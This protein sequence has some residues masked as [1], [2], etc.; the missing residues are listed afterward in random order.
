MTPLFVSY[1]CDWCDG[2]KRPTVVARGFVVWPEEVV[3]DAME[4]YV[5][6]TRE[7][8]AHYQRSTGSSGE[9]REVASE[10]PIRW[11][12]GRGSIKNLRLAD[13][14]YSIYPDFRFEPAPYRAFLADSERERDD[15]EPVTQY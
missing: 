12:P 8:A 1:V 9:I 11:Q 14:L 7:M 13:R 4:L 3:V 15:I 2:L 10:Y 6:P 5:F